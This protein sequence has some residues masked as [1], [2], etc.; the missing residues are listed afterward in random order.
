VVQK[1]RAKKQNRHPTINASLMQT[2]I[3]CSA[4]K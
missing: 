2:P 3:E 4:P 1:S